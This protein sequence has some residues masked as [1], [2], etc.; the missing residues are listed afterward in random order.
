MNRAFLLAVT[1]AV[2]APD[3]MAQEVSEGVKRACR[4]T[5][6]QTART[7]AYAKRAKLDPASQVRKVADSWLEGVQT[8]ML[9]SASR[10]DHLSEGEL[11]ALGYS[12]CVER[13]PTNVR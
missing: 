3:V 8:H 2:S 5:A 10:A 11:A 12:Y 1:L 6:D 4:S 13:R 7:I 9:L